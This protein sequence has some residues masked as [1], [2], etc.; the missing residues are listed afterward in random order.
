MKKTVFTVFGLCFV[1]IGLAQTDSSQKYFKFPAIPAFSIIKVP[2]SSSFTNNKLKKNKPVV[3]FFFN[4][5]CDHCHLETKNLVAK[6]EQLKNVQI[7]MISILDFNA[8]KKFYNEY[9]L[10]EHPNITVARETT[11]NLPGFFNIHSIPD[12]YVYDKKGK[13]ISTFKKEFPVE[14]IAALF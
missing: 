4:P 2:D 7:L 5:D 13:F 12:V 8:I 14:K 6:I 9:K 3:F 10:A 1:I 11:Y